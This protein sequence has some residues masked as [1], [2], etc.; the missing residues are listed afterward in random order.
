[1]RRLLAFLL[2]GLAIPSLAAAAEWTKKGPLTDSAGV[3]CLVVSPQQLGVRMNVSGDGFGLAAFNLESFEFVAAAKGALDRGVRAL[4]Q[5]EKY[6][7][8]TLADISESQSQT[9][10]ASLHSV[11][12]WSRDFHL[13]DA[14]KAGER[15]LWKVGAGTTFTT[16]FNT[17][18]GTTAI[19][20][21]RGSSAALKWLE[22]CV[23]SVK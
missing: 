5:V 11:F 17:L 19:Y 13:F 16:D 21:L 2:T 23:E 3:Y 7:A 6:T 4:L 14:M 9:D 10:G 15:M 22:A 12:L 20:S 8:W 18:P 1:M